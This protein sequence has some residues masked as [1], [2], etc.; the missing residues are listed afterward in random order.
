MKLNIWREGTLTQLADCESAFDRGLCAVGPVPAH[1]ELV[2]G[3]AS[4]P[5]SVEREITK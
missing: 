3:V 1:N 4:S 5:L 2:G